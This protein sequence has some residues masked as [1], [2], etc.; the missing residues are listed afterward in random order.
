MEPDQ[1][2]RKF[3]NTLN[4]FVEVYILKVTTKSNSQPPWFDTECYLKCKEKERLHKKY[5]STKSTAD[6]LKFTLCRKEFKSLIR[7]KVRGSLY[8]SNAS[9]GIRKQFWSHFKAKSTQIESPTY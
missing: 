2:W 9:N 6:E 1:A 3:K 5:K 8:C 7:T 4:H